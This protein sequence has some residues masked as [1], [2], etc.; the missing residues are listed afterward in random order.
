LQTPN[1][2]TPER[3]T[4]AHISIVA[5]ITEPELRRCLRATELFNGFLNRFSVF[6]VR[7]AR[8]LPHG[9]VPD[10][11]E[12]VTRQLHQAVR[13]ARQVDEMGFDDGAADLWTDEYANLTRDRH[14]LLDAATSRAEAHALRWSMIYAVLDGSPLIRLEHLR[15]GLEV[16]RYAFDSARVL[17]G[18][19]LGNPLADELL[20][21]LRAR[22]D[23]MSRAAIYDYLGR[24]VRR[25]QIDQALVLLEVEGLARRELRET[26]GRPSEVWHAINAKNAISRGAT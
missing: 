10:G 4:G 19:A 2:N 25:D 18:D 22:P 7:R 6:L 24:N 9:G 16:W 11:R 14:G 8:Y 3:A 12:A 13:A 1:K 21:A 15:A 17:W 5:H 23:G 26:G 20:R